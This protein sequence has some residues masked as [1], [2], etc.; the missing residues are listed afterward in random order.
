LSRV[1][2]VVN[3][4]FRKAYPILNGNVPVLVEV[5]VKVGALVDGGGTMTSLLTVTVTVAEVLLFPTASLATAVNTWL[6]L[7]AEDVFQLT[8]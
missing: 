1:T 4:P 3:C 5:R 7:V 8:E 2:E 6:A